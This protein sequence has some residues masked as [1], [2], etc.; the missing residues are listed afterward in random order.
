LLTTLL[1]GT[2]LSASAGLNAYLPLLILALADRLT[3]VVD[4]DQPYDVLSSNLG[5]LVLLLVLPIELIPDK[6]SKLDHL[7]DLLHTAIRP[8]SG[9]ILFM[10]YASQDDVLQPVVGM[11]I[12]LLVAGAV[13]AIKSSTRPHISITTRGIGNPFISIIEDFLA[14]FL[15]ILAIFVPISMIVALPLAA[16]LLLRSYRRMRS[17]ETRIMALLGTDS[18]RS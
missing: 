11:V 13:H 10:A 12:G 3:S 1:A 15:A 8:A 14:I 18:T 7:N 4:L 5:L 6:I 17:G 2:G 16:W 9:A